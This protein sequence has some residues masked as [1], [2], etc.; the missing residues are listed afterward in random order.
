MVPNPAEAS[1]IPSPCA[2]IARTTPKNETRCRPAPGS[3]GSR[4]AT[5]IASSGITVVAIETAPNPPTAPSAA[6]NGAPHR[7]RAIHRDPD[8]GHRLARVFGTHPGYCPGHDA[9]GEQAVAQPQQDASAGECAERR[10]VRCDQ[11]A[12]I[13]QAGQR[14]DPEPQQDGEFGPAP[15]RDRPGDLPRQQRGDGGKPDDDADDRRAEPQCHARPQPEA[16]IAGYR[17]PNNRG[18]QSGR[19]AAALRSGSGRQFGL[20]RSL[21]YPGRCSA[22][23]GR[24]PSSIGVSW[25]EPA[26]KPS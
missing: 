4:I 2:Q 20:A 15:I 19:R 13:G 11:R 24:P 8:P 3:A 16:S 1:T 26:I 22:R 23:G 21:G 17:R 14:R 12:E 5:G 10:S 25:R 6:P 9:G 18:R 7:Q